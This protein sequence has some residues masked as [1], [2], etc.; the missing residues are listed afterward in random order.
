MAGRK[1]KPTALK[2]LEGNPGKR[3]I[4]KKEPI[5]GKGIPTCPEW[6]LTEAKTEWER[7]TAVMD[8]M[9]VLTEVDRAAFAAYCQSYT[10]W[11]EAQEHIDSEWSTFET[12]K[13][14]QQQAPW[15]GIANTNQ[16]LMMQ[17]ASEF[18]LTHSARSRIVAGSTKNR[19]TE[20]E[21]EALLGGDS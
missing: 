18:G 5:P 15:V 6:L 8:Q 12:D 14:Y 7:L 13:G 9:G 1:P 10:R 11:K 3:K 21:M 2:T 16:K 20:D 19:E 17:A 4:N